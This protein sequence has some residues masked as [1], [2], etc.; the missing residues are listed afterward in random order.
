MK[1]V[2]II[3]N[4]FALVHMIRLELREVPKEGEKFYYAGKMECGKGRDFFVEGEIRG[5]KEQ[6]DGHYWEAYINLTPES[7]ESYYGKSLP[8]M[9]SADAFAEEYQSK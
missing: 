5:I 7:K 6:D 2:C 4:Q 1:R 9:V 8:T 3:D